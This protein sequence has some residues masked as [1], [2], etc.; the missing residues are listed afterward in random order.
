MASNGTKNDTNQREVPVDET[1]SGWEPTV[2]DEIN[3]ALAQN[4]GFKRIREALKQRL[5]ETGWSQDLREYCTALFRSGEAT[6]YPE[7]HAI[8]MGR[9]QAGSA[10]ANGTSNGVPAPDL[11]I[12][13][14]AQEGGAEAV[15]KELRQIVKPKK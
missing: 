6:T 9:I 13:I 12:P 2:Q 15:K 11:S 14:S 3:L 4:G 5:D 10:A 8:I 7:A 1:T